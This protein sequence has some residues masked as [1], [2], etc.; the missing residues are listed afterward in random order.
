[1]SK[2]PAD[3]CWTREFAH[4]GR[5]PGSWPQT[6]ALSRTAC[7]ETELH[8]QPTRSAEQLREMCSSPAV[9]AQAQC[10]DD[11]RIN[12]VIGISEGGSQTDVT[13]ERQRLHGE[14]GEDNDFRSRGTE[15]SKKKAPPQ[16]TVVSNTVYNPGAASSA[17]IGSETPAHREISTPPSPRFS[18]VTRRWR[19]FVV[20][21]LQEESA[22][23]RR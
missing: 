8:C 18:P 3:H 21:L 7:L 16:T 10:S 14:G 17:T 9:C 19:L 5:D 23:E 4:D 11:V 12:T 6:K 13:S 22:R 20:S 2:L 1:M 15:A